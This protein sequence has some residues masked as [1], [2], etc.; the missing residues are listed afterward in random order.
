MSKIKKYKDRKGNSTAHLY[1]DETSSIF[2][3]VVRVG[4]QVRK[5]SLD[6]TEYLE[7]L[8]RLPKAIEELG[9]PQDKASMASNKIC[10]DYWVDLRKQKVANDNRQ[11]TMVKMDSVWKLHLDPFIGNLRPDQISKAL[12]TDFVLW[13]KREFKNQQLFNPY[14]YLSNLFAFMLIAGAITAEQVP[15]LELSKK[16]KRQHAQKKGRV[17]GSD[18]RRALRSFG[19][20][21]IRL[22]I[23]LG[24]V[25]GMRKMEIGALEKSRITKESG[26]FMIGLTEDDTKTGLPRV[27]GVPKSLES[28][29]EIQVAASGRSRFLF[30]TKDGLSNL[31]SQMVDKEWRE[32]KALAKIE[33][34]LRFHDL[35]HSRATEFALQNVNPAIACTILGM[36]LKMYQ[37][38]YLNLSGKDLLITIDQIDLGALK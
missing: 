9:T 11:S 4:K 34:R 33:G 24:D 7:A 31:P 20:N 25:L 22:I 13:H 23:G 5:K 36:S 18:E 32:V 12:G 37:T 10:R 14:K 35:R 2:Y 15:E 8:S 28:M 3:A 19:S 16:E 30:P 27:L 26:R 1:Q 17:I 6:T 21:R 29:L 38:T